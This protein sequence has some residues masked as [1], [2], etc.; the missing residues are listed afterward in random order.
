MNPYRSSSN[1]VEYHIDFPPQMVFLWIVQNLSLIKKHSPE[2]LAFLVEILEDKGS[3]KYS[4]SEWEGIEEHYSM[5]TSHL[6]RNF[7]YRAWRSSHKAYERKENGQVF[8]YQDI[9]MHHTISERKTIG[10]FFRRRVS[11]QKR[12]ILKCIL[13]WDVHGDVNAQISKKI[14]IEKLLFQLVKNKSPPSAS[15][16]EITLIKK[17]TEKIQADEV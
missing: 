6:R 9:Q 1:K 14:K 7:V 4:I 2:L 3:G 15:K 17:V 10:F 8:K 16:R 11:S 12:K 13:N 5:I